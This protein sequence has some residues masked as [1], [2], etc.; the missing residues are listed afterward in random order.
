MSA[1]HALG[2]VAVR[3]RDDAH[4]HAGGSGFRS[5]DL[6]LSTLQ[7]PQQLSL[8]AEAHLT[9]FVQEDRPL[10]SQAQASGLVAIGSCEA[11]FDVTEQL[12]F[13][14]GLGKGGAVDRDEPA[15]GPQRARV[16]VLSDEILA[17]AAFAG[18]QDLSVACRNAFGSGTHLAHRRTRVHDHGIVATW[19]DRQKDRRTLASHTC[20]QP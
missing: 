9:H 5:N 2:Q 8:H 16:N 1:R 20:Y 15:L 6:K 19:S 17:D 14:E 18:D 12:G 11:A 4:V 7:E 13:E 3:G 10:M